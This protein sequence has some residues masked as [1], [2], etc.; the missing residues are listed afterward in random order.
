MHAHRSF[1]ALT[2]RAQIAKETLYFTLLPYYVFN[3]S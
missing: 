1:H 2:K 3:L